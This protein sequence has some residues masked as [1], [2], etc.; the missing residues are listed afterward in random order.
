[1]EQEALLVFDEGERLLITD[2]Y[3]PERVWRDEE[4]ALLEF[5]Q[6]DWGVETGSSVLHAEVPNKQGREVQDMPS[7]CHHWLGD[8]ASLRQWFSAA[9]RAIFGESC[10]PESSCGR[11]M[12]HTPKHQL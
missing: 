7:A 10:R 9:N 3:D 8:E 4:L 5:R 2:D 6:E 12:G 1:M 11:R